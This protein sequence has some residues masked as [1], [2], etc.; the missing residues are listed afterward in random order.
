MHEEKDYALFFRFKMGTLSRKW[1]LILPVSKCTQSQQSESR[2]G[3]AEKH[4][5]R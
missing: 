4:T 5:A 1:V 2:G 3:L